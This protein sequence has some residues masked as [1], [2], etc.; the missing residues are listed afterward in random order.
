MHFNRIGQLLK[1]KMLK[2]KS[3]NYYFCIYSEVDFV[4]EVEAMNGCSES[5]RIRQVA[6]KYGISAGQ[7]RGKYYRQKKEQTEPDA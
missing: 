4:K 7:C 1:I 3:L 2:V 6:K 5:E